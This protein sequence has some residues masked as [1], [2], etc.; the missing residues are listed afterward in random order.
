MGLTEG[1]RIQF[2]ANGAGWGWYIDPN[3]TDSSEFSATASPNE[4]VAAPDSSAAGKLDLLTVL[5]HELGHVLGL[6][7]ADNVHDEMATT[8]TPGLRRL[9]EVSAEEMRAVGFAK[10]VTDATRITRTLVAP[11]P[12]FNIAA[13][14]T[15]STLA[16]PAG[17]SATGAAVRLRGVG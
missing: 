4:F 8:V 2:D 3:P 13:N 7:H 17:W 16:A 15:L 6:G 1:N 9:P 11:G 5:I 10:V 14:P 12:R